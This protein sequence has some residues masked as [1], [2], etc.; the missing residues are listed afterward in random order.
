MALKKG[1]CIS[2]KQ[3]QRRYL[4]SKVLKVLKDIRTAARVGKVAE[5]IV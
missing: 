1:I 3:D 5:Q 4:A 2:S